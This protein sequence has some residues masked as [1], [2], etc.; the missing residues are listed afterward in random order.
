MNQ[1]YP[2]TKEQVRLLLLYDFRIKKKAANSI[3]DINTAFGPDTVSKSTAYDWYSRFQKGNESLEDQPRT[4]RPSEFDNSALQEALEANNR[5]TSRELADLLGVSHTTIL[6]HLAELGK[7]AKLG[8]WIVDP[9]EVFAEFRLADKPLTEDQIMGEVLS[10]LLGDT[11]IW[12]AGV[13]WDRDTFPNKT[14]FAPYAYKTQLNT[15]KFNID[16]MARLNSTKE[17]YTNK[18]W[19]KD[20]KAR[21]ATNLESLEEF[22]VKI[23]IRSNSSGQ[24][25]RKYE[26]Y[27]M[28]FRAPKLEHGWWS[29][30]FFDCDGFHQQWV[31]MYAAPF[32][33]WDSLRNK[34]K[35]MGAVTVAMD[36][37]QMDIDQCPDNYWVPNVFKDSHKCD[38]KTSYCVPILGRGFDTGSYK[39]ECLQGFEYPY[40]NLITYYDGQLVESEYENIVK[41]KPSRYDTLKCRLAGAS[42]IGLNWLLLP[43]LLTLLL[44]P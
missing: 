21:W 7:K 36:I 34:L 5:Q 15:R 10:L 39:C 17:V 40:E 32:F 23:H 35:F 25:V 44:Q 2:L 31:V 6:H 38:R 26:R 43:L 11:R 8:C 33:G 16:D 18:K 24:Y 4:G 19:F 9:T 37:W 12:G 41:D 22:F 3:A 42:T 27:P 14:L 1:P 13:Y 20:L 28:S 30:P 29:T